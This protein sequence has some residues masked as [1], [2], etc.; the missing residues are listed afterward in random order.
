M[1]APTAETEPLPRRAR[2]RQATIE[3]IKT[4]AL[5]QLADQGPAALSLRA[6]A[7]DMGTASSAL[8]R[9]FASS[10]DLISALCADAYCDAA[11]ALETAF[12]A[13]P[14]EDSTRRWW[15]ICHA[16]REWSLE[17][18]AG[19]TLIFGTPVPG[20][21][22][23]P[24]VT[25]PAAGRFVSVLLRA[26][27]AA[28][29]SGAAHPERTQVPAEIQAGELFQDLID[30][31]SPGFSPQLAALALNAML[32]ILGYLAMEVF[33]ALPRLIADSDQLFDAHV[34]TVMLGL[35][36]DPDVVADV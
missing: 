26:Y 4:R 32:S 34:R 33:G 5:R 36:F 9:Y 7:R 2:Y 22:A 20:H 14:I 28:V 16:L 10:Q 3:E 29:E 13:Q 24:Q 30:R 18:P 12:E 11:N 19:F 8:Y 23:P 25:G 15:A 21:E 6:I 35:G 17:C 31:T 27:E 1:S